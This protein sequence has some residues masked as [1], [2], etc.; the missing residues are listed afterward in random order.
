LAAPIGAI[1][2]P[3]GFFVS[4]LSPDAQSPSNLIYLAYVGGAILALGVL[5]LGIGLLRRRDS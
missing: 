5:I 3:L 4:V 2:T 1:L